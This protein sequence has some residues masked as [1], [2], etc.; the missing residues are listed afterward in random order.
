MVEIGVI[1]IC[2]SD[3]RSEHISW[4]ICLDGVKVD[5][6]SMILEPNSNIDITITIP[7]KMLSKD[8]TYASVIRCSVYDCNTNVI[9]DRVSQITVRS[10]FDTDLRRL[11]ELTAKYINPLNP[12]IKHFVDSKDGLLSKTMGEKYVVSGYQATETIFLQLKSVFDA[13][14]DSGIS[15]VSDVSA[16]NENGCFQRIRDPPTVIR[17]RSGNCIELS[18]LMASIYECMGFESI[19]VFPRGH[20]IVGIVMDTNMYETNSVMAE[21]VADSVVRLNNGGY[22]DALFIES[23]A[24]ANKDFTFAEA[25]TVAKKEVEDEM[26]FITSNNMYTMKIKSEKC[27]DGRQI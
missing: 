23:T 21:G 5:S 17:D 9:L 15:Y 25:V 7:V 8:D 27:E 2:N 22:V 6:S 1:G 11:P 4:T 12:E 26:G 20:A 19:I 16:L 3:N 10:R 18:I 24:V 13:I 14:R